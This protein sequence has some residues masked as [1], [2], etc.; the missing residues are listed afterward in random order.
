MLWF[1]CV[2]TAAE[3]VSVLAGILLLSRLALA[4]LCVAAKQV[5]EITLSVSV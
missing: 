3:L 2:W 4:R 5:I 1:V